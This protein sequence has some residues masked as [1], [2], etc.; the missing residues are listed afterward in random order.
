MERS[1]CLKKKYKSRLPSNRGVCARGLSLVA[2]CDWTY[3]LWMLYCEKAI[4]N[5][6]NYGGAITF[7]IAISGEKE[8][9]AYIPACFGAISLR[10]LW[11]WRVEGGRLS[12]N[13]WFLACHFA[14]FGVLQVSD[15][16]IFYEFFF[17]VFVSFIFSAL[18]GRQAWRVQWN[19]RVFFQ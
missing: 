11:K 12:V 8:D 15:F 6:D 5:C 16:T 4:I 3:Q 7:D 18:Y 19:N 17:Q 9:F 13:E 10:L 14:N 2:S 1:S